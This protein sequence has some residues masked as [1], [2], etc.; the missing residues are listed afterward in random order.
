MKVLIALDVSGS[1]NFKTVIKHIQN[2]T[3]NEVPKDAVVF[4]RSFDLVW[5]E[6]LTIEKIISGNFLG[7][8]GSSIIPV[9]RECEHYDYTFVLTDG[10][11]DDL[12]KLPYN[13]E[14]VI[15]ED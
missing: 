8:A 10:Y 4:I 15:L 5:I 13:T 11:M 6:Y 3:N 7:G 12:D 2:I 14:V 1:M 9:L